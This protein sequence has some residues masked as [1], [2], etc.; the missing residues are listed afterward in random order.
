[1]QIVIAFVSFCQS[2]FEKPVFHGLFVL[3]IVQYKQT[4]SDESKLPQRPYSKCCSK[5]EVHNLLIDYCNDK[6]RNPILANYLQRSCNREIERINE[7]AIQF[8]TEDSLKEVD[9][10]QRIELVRIL[11]NQF[12]SVLEDGQYVL[13]AKK[14]YI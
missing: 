14:S 13:K 1:M 6:R 2:M 7:Q 10:G 8:H 5:G 4:K 3:Y 11:R 12:D 9:R